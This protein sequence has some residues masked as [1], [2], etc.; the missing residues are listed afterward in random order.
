MKNL[1]KTSVKLHYNTIGAHSAI[2]IDSEIPHYYLF[3]KNGSQIGGA[4]VGTIDPALIK[5]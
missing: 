1:N 3:K 2:I 4:L 5:M